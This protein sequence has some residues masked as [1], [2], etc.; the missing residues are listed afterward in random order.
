MS[1]MWSSPWGKRP[2]SARPQSLQVPFVRPSARLS[3][4]IMLSGLSGSSLR[5]SRSR[6]SPSSSGRSCSTAQRWIARP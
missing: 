6:A 3:F 4:S 1:P 5:P 2:S